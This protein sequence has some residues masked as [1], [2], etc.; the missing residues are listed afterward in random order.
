[1][2]DKE[3]VKALLKKLNIGYMDQRFTDEIYIETGM[4]NVE[5]RDGF[6][7]AFHFDKHGKFEKFEIGD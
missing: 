5:G 3:Q 1:M 4:A 7:A 2:N 6:G